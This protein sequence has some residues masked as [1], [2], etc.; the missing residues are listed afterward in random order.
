LCGHFGPN[1][2]AAGSDPR[3]NGDHQIVWTRPELIRH[4]LNGLRNDLEKG[5]AP[6]CMDGSHGPITNVSHQDGQAISRTDGQGDP[7]LI[8]NEG[9]PLAQ[10]A[11]PIGNQ[12]FV[13]V[14]LLDRCKIG[15]IRP[16]RAQP[17]AEAMLQPRDVIE[18]LRSVH[19]F[20]IE[21]KQPSL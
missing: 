10:A 17:G 2:E 6:A 13:G 14:N 5:P 16:V 3:A 19:I 8:R 12:Y 15:R 4:R 9:I 11:S 1:F 20:P 18:R 7:R 21:A